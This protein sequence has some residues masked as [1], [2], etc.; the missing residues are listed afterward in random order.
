MEVVVEGKINSD[1]KT[2]R[3]NVD[4][5]YTS[6][7]VACDWYYNH[8]KSDPVGVLYSPVE[9]NIAFELKKEI[10]YNLIWTPLPGLPLGAFIVYGPLGI[11][12]SPGA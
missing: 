11:Y 3:T 12:A 1:V 5:S 4:L 10:P 6:V 2:P 7:S 9:H 8:A